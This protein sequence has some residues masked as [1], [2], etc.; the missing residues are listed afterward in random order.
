MCFI[1]G[2]L[3]ASKFTEVHE[4]P[5]K[6]GTNNACLAECLKCGKRP[7]LLERCL[8]GGLKVYHRR[9]FACVRCQ[10]QLIKG[11]YRQTDSTPEKNT[12]LFECLDHEKEDFLKSM[13]ILEVF[14]LC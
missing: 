4:S 3:P 11:A 9:C 8:I 13:F 12:P 14:S 7:Y 10:K 2:V 5:S 1:L 6:S